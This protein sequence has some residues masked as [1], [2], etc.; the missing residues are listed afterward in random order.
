MALRCSVHWNIWMA[1]WGQRGGRWWGSR[2]VREREGSTIG[3]GIRWIPQVGARGSGRPAATVRV[4]G[5]GHRPRTAANR[6]AADRGGEG[7]CPD[8]GSRTPTAPPQGHLWARVAR[9]GD[10]NDNSSRRINANTFCFRKPGPIPMGQVHVGHRPLRGDLHAGGFGVQRWRRRPF[11]KTAV[12]S[13]V[14]EDL[15]AC[16][17][18]TRGH[19][20]QI[21]HCGC[22]ANGPEIQGIGGLKT[23]FIL[24]TW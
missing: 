17:E 15:L 5:G 1:A 2:H 19:Y 3:Q 6:S 12:A 9:T 11:R 14:L 4:R 20:N 21:L 16:T 8:G 10:C 7:T 24:A 18:I 23:E 13:L 22:M